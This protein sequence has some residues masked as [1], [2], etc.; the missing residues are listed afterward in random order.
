MR[1][2]RIVLK[3]KPVGVP[4]LDDF[5]LTAADLPE[6]GEGEMRLRTVYLELDPYVRSAIAG[7]HMSGTV[8]IGDVVPGIAV[9]QIEQS[10]IQGF[11]PGDY[12]V[13]E[14]GWQSH[15]ISDGEGVIHI[16][17]NWQPLSAH[18]GVMGM[19]GLTAYAALV[20]IARPMPG[21]TVLVSAATGGVGSMAGQLAQIMGS[22]A[23]GLAGSERKCDY[24]VDE[25][26]YAACINYKDDN[27][28]VKLKAACPDGVDVYIDTVGGEMLGTAMKHLAMGAR[29]IQMGM[30]GA[31]SGNVEPT[32]S[33]IPLI[34]A[35]ASLTGFVVYD[36]YD[37]MTEFKNLT[38]Q[39]I[40]QGRVK[41]R[42]DR[43]EGL[44]TAPAAF[45]KLISGENFGKSV[46]VVGPETL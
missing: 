8:N 19:P 2:S 23:V 44:E 46:V 22:R 26:G 24:A 35:R 25:L 34:L 32:P 4:E 10:H 30:I 28:E 36:H 33:L 12:V 45:R 20:R 5:E 38:A 17:P 39:W 14:P 29:I 9:C 1:I 31:Y 11:H 37:L 16:A 6:P 7:R 21:E 3:K 42:E 15:S 43:S 41:F 18:L 40:K 13:A 27:W